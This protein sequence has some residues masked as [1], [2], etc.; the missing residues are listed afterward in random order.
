MTE[1]ASPLDQG[2]LAMDQAH[3]NAASLEASDLFDADWY[4]AEYP[5]VQS[6]QMPPAVHYLWL[7]ARLGRNPSPRFS[8]RSYL[9]A[10]PDVAQAG[11]NPLLHFLLAGCDEGRSGTILAAPSRGSTETDVNASTFGEHRPYVFLPPADLDRIAAQWSKDSARPDAQGR[12]IAIFS[13]ITGSYDNI[14]HHEHLIPGADYLLYSDA[15]KPR[16]VYQPR[17][18]PWFDCDTVRAARFIKTHPHMLLGDYRIAVWVDG[19]ILIRGDLLPIIQR[20][21]ESGL[22][23]GAVPHPLRQSVYA[24]A[25]EC[26]K[27]GK[28]DE[29]TIRRQMQRYRREEFDCEDLIESNLL[30]FRLGHPSL[31][32][33][34]DTWWA[35]IESGSRRDQLSLNYALHKTGVEWLALTQRPHSVRDHPALALMHHRSQFNPAEPGVCLPR[36]RERTFAEVRAE[37]IAAQS[38]RR[39]DVIVCVH[40]A[41][42]MVARCLDSVRTGQNPDRHRIIIIDDGSGRDTAELV[43]RFAA[44]TPN[45]VLIRNAVAGGY[46]RAANQGLKAMDADM[47][48]LLNSDTVVAPGWIEKLLDA[49]FSN[50]GVGIVG[51]MSSAAS[52]QS[53]PE[54]QSRHDQ[55]AINDLPPGWSAADMDAWCER[56]APA[57]FLPRVPLVHGFCFAVTREAVERIGYLDED[58]FPDGYGEE[59]DY[60]LRATDAGVGLAIATH[61]YVFHEKSQSY[62]SDRRISLMKRGNG[63]IRELHG[64]ERVARAVRSMQQNPHLGR[65]RTAAARLFAVTTPETPA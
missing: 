19:N 38:A 6:L 46:T 41:R 45:T 61:T 11:I 30:M 21:E 4:L 63:K 64:D 36:P 2:L 42:E 14:N 57:D 5:D 49:A 18:A 31:A 12:G 55:T 47:A 56:M 59:N 51:P 10:N 62:Q 13:A 24:E 53:I 9:D 20:F 39:A 35:Q 40:N 27:R 23:F 60:C 25:V 34:L 22:A 43:S 48:I 54:H 15:P 26:M 3:A 33:L 52:H 8:T 32:P 50:P 7:G 37:R 29:A 17:Q 44:D 1:A 65:L 16:Y 58:S 28:D